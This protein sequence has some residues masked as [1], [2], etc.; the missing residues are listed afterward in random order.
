M[1]KHKTKSH[2]TP[3]DFEEIMESESF[4][5]ATEYKA[6]Y[7]F[8]WFDKWI[9]ANKTNDDADIIDALDRVIDQ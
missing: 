3:Y 9:E 5:N 8:A 1:N 6:T 4:T 7:D 2:D